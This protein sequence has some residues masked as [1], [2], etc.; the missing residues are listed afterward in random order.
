[1]KTLTI[2]LLSSLTTVIAIMAVAMMVSYAGVLFPSLSKRSPNQQYSQQDTAN[3]QTPRTDN[4]ESSVSKSTDPHCID[5]EY[6]ARWSLMNEAHRCTEY[7]TDGTNVYYRSSSQAIAK[8]SPNFVIYGKSGTSATDGKIVIVAGQIVD[9]ADPA[10]YMPLF[11]I[12]G[13][14]AIFGVDRKHVY[15][16]SAFFPPKIVGNIDENF[17]AYQFWQNKFGRRMRQELDTTN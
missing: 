13:D 4:Q 15:V 17:Y 5:L 2:V 12:N 11:D 14:E 16:F 7:F 9:D 1:M 6:P 3:E 8:V 10:T